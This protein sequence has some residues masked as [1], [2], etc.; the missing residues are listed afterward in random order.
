V[1]PRN[2]YISH[3]ILSCIYNQGDHEIKSY[4]VSGILLGRKAGP[5]EENWIRITGRDSS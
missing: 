1:H 2:I 5:W 4:D 3:V